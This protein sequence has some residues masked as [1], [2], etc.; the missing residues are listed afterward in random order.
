MTSKPVAQLFNDLRAECFLTRPCTS[1]DNPISEAQ[2]KT[3]KWRPIYT[4]RFGS[5]EDARSWADR[6]F[7]WYNHD[8]CHIVLALMH[9][10]I[11]HHGL[12][13]A[14]KAVQ[15]AVLD[16]AYDDTPERFAN[17]PPTAENAAQFRLDQ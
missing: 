4:R 6:V 9:C 14:M 15:Q 10:A 11:V 1:N 2:F 17:G 12:A 7:Q 16:K 3:L 5:P 8:H 13:K